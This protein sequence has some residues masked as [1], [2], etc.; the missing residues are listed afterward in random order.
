M[1]GPIPP[2]LK[3]ATTPRD[4]YNIELQVSNTHIQWRYVGF[5]QW[6]NLV[7]LSDLVGPVGPKGLQ[8]SKGVKG[9][10]GAEGVGGTPG[11]KGNP[12]IRGAEGRQ[13]RVGVQGSPGKDGKDGLP[14]S[15]GEDGKTGPAGNDGV[16]GREIE[17]R[18]LNRFIQWR[19]VGEKDW[20]N[21]ILLSELRGERGEQ[22]KRGL[23]GQGGARGTDGVGL[24]SGGD[25]GQIPEKID[26]TDFNIQWVDQAVAGS[27]TNNTYSYSSIA[28]PQLF[29]PDASGVSGDTDDFTLTNS[30]AVAFVTHNGQVLDDS[31]YSLAG[32]IL[33]VTPDN[34][35]A[36]T[37]DEVLVFQHS[38]AITAEG[39]QS[40]YR[41]VTSTDTATAADHILG[42]SGTF[43][44]ALFSAA[45][46]AGKELIIKNSG[47]GIITVDPDGS[48]TID[49]YTTVTLL[50]T[51]SITIISDGTN[52]NIV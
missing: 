45:G 50:P 3:P 44:E 11:T 19:Y 23:I 35:F 51:E 24:P 13:G 18:K 30:N 5:R 16:D 8:G 41:A 39:F 40:T 37:S 22:G 36:D 15:P 6:A 25:A 42:C 12:G 14:G 29:N 2:K 9:E 10:R 21:L 38:F 4:G 49:E 7:A 52:W 34:G 32:A 47:T 46:L 26:G 48:E 31:E 43:T 28:A 27:I 17:I 20:E 33:T 1:F